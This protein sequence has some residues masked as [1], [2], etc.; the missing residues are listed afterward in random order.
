MP[1]LDATNNYIRGKDSEK[2]CSDVIQS[3]GLA[4]VTV[5]IGVYNRKTGIPIAGVINQPFVFL[6][7]DTKR[8][9][10]PQNYFII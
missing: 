10:S 8:Y 2:I 4:V 5:L 7:E 3:R 9:L 1:F 6:D